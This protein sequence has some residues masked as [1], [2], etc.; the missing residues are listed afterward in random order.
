LKAII[1]VEDEAEQQPLPSQGSIEV[2]WLHRSNSPT[3]ARGV[4]AKRICDA[5]EDVDPE[6]FIW[7]ACEKADIRTVRKFLSP[8]QRD[9]KRQ[10][11]AWYWERT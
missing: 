11:L 7:V 6:T 9:R 1:E 4:L 3:G 8:K 2:E 10:Y 5:L